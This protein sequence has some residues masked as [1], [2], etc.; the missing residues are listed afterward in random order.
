LPATGGAK[1][2]ITTSGF[3]VVANNQLYGLAFDDTTNT[4]INSTANVGTLILG[5]I[6]ILNDAANGAGIVLDDGGTSVTT[7]GTNSINTRSGVALSLTNATNIGAAGLTFTNISAGNNDGNPDPANGLVLNNTG[8]SG[9]LTVSGGTIRFMTASGVMLTSTR[10]INFSNMTIQNSA[11]DG[12]TGL[13]VTNFTMANSTV[14]S[15]GNAVLDRG[16][17]MTNL[18]GTSSIT[19]ST[20]TGSTEDNLYVKN[21][22]GTSTLTVTTTTFSNNS[23]TLGND[24]I[25]FL[26]ADVSGSN[27][28]NMSI[29]VTNCTFNNHR[30]DHFQALTD[31]VSSATQTIVF[32]N[33]SLTGDGG[34]TLGGNDLGAGLTFNPSGTATVNFNISNNGQSSGTPTNLPWTGAVVSAITINSSSNSTMSG[35]INNNRIG[36]AAVVDSGSAQGDGINITANNSSDIT[37][38]ITNNQIRQYANL[39]GLNLSVVDGTTDTLNATITGNTISNPGSFAS[40]GIFTQ[41]GAT[42]TDTSFMC[43][44]I[45]GAGA[46]ANSIAGSGANGGTDFRVRQRFGTTVRLP[47]Y[48]GGATDTAAVVA[49]IQGRNTG[50]ETGSAT[51]QAPG[52]GFVG[53]AACASAFAF[54]LPGFA[55]QQENLARTNINTEPSISTQPAVAKQPIQ[56]AARTVSHH[57]K[58][59]RT[60]PRNE[61]ASSSNAVRNAPVASATVS[62]PVLTQPAAAKPAGA[63]STSRQPV[64]A[65]QDKNSRRVIVK[66]GIKTLAGETV[67]HSVGTLLAGKTVHI[68]FQ[69]TVNNPYLGGATVSNQGTVSGS[70]FSDVLTDDPAF[71]GLNDPTTTPI[72]LI[73][74]V[75]VADAQANEP[76]SGSAPM[77]FTVSLSAPAAAGGASVHYATADQ[78]PAANHAV[79]GV[80]YTAIPDTVLN[81]AAGEQFKTIS[82]SILFD[83]PGS[84]VDETFLLNLSNPTNAIIVDGQAVGTIKQ[85]NAA[86]TFLI[87]E[88][89]TSGPGGAGDDF[90]ELYNNS[91]SPLTV[92]ASDASGRL[93][94]VQDGR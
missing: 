34:T 39:A 8:A 83:G 33:N 52:A 85:G 29:S 7:V 88:L 70:N 63:R 36:N 38:A 16:V 80:D 94:P 11:D 23:S 19:G 1:P 66:P 87:S 44:D 67:S 28:A 40:N 71:A 62:K 55:N 17:E 50:A 77:V 53:G 12:I 21:G 3:N 60:A 86:G 82:V 59:T 92:A 58:I 31:A 20:I 13:N 48:A 24:G 6:V 32:Q 43:I 79:A 61:V 35:T 9:G 22:T 64:N 56:N 46:L 27:N 65:M 2:S 4:A 78:A 69:V 90:V 25:H 37:V 68:Q 57:A 89:R 76:V 91:D 26:G 73:P 74:N 45:G 47:G 49:F 75:S 72:L 54:N 15:N 81:F 41:A 5:D 14:S 84:E 93:W 42:G 51:V 18:L 30:G 10:N